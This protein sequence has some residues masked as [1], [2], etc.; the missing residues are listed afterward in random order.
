M[1]GLTLCYE[2]TQGHQH[3]GTCHQSDQCGNQGYGYN[4]QDEKNKNFE[5]S[6]YK[7]HKSIS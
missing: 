4:T 5:Q 6:N 7:A 2:S 1:Q 3:I